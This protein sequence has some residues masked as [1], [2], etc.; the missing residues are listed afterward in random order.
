MSIYS[1]IPLFQYVKRSHFP[2]TVFIPNDQKLFFVIFVYIA[3][4]FQEFS[5]YDHWFIPSPLHRKE[6]LNSFG[7]RSLRLS[8]IG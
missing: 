5:P 1:P 8:A 3:H 2:H 7:H 6:G 4:S